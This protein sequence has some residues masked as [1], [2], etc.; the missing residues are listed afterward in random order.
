MKPDVT[1][2]EKEREREKWREIERQRERRENHVSF[3]LSAF[4]IKRLE[5]I[6]NCSLACIYII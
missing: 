2:R 6:S 1:E 5:N 3:K 4:C